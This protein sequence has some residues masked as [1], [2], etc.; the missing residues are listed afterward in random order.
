[1]LTSMK[2]KSGFLLYIDCRLYS[3][4]FKYY[5][6]IIYLGRN[7]NI[8]LICFFLVL[9][10]DFSDFSNYINVEILLVIF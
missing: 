7:I 4:T 9:I 10:L 5:T 8:N 6:L 2:I 1:M 3:V